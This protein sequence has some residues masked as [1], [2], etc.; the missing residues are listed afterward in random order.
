MKIKFLIS[1]LLFFSYTLFGQKQDTIKL[2]FDKVVHIIL[3]YD[4]D[5]IQTGS[6]QF[7]AIKVNEKENIVRVVA[8]EENFN[9]TTNMNIIDKG[10]NIYSFPVIYS[11][12]AKGINSIFY[13]KNKPKPEQKAK[14]N[15]T[16]KA[17]LIFPEKIIY[18]YAGGDMIKAEKTT[19][20]NILSIGLVDSPGEFETNVFAVCNNGQEY[21]IILTDGI[22]KDYLYYIEKDTNK[23]AKVENNTGVLQD[24]I[25]IL[26]KKDPDFLNLGLIK[27]KL[28][29]CIPNIFI[30]EKYFYFTYEIYNKSNINYEID[31]IKTYFVDKKTT[32]N[33]V[34]QEKVIECVPDGTTKETIVN[35][36]S[37]VKMIYVYDKFTIPDD[38]VFKIEIFEKNGGRNIEF[39]LK[40]K[41]IINAKEL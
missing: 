33:S 5:Y 24:K 17:F 1:F 28:I 10:G 23:K 14:L 37:K 16:N 12:Y 31:F 36:N 40:N 41:D 27:N 4:V 20:N 11:S 19:A 18:Y 6:E 3:P 7:E 21:N 2:N 34:Q 26:L 9:T 35:G 30:D 8:L 13:I 39:N 25:E 38:K 15:A 22:A 32:K 29:F